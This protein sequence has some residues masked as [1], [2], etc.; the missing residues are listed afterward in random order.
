MF[1]S[2]RPIYARIICSSINMAQSR[3]CVGRAKPDFD[4][5]HPHEKKGKE[6]NEARICEAH[7]N[8]SSFSHTTHYFRFCEQIFFKKVEYF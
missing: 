8:K 3:L 2:Y 4:H 7:T 1:A 5:T 6:T